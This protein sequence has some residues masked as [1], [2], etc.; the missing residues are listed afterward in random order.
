MHPSLFLYNRL[1]RQPQRFYFYE[2]AIKIKE[3]ER[4]VFNS[5]IF[6]P[7]YRHKTATFFRLMAF[8]HTTARDSR[9]GRPFPLAHASFSGGGK[10]S[11]RPL[12]LRRLLGR[13]SAAL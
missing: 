5:F 11:E 9:N 10:K 2:T 8:F 1:V 7:T 6:T 12:L 4:I 3:N 13:K